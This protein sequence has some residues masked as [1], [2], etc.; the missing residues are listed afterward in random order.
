MDT[1]KTEKRPNQAGQGGGTNQA[2]DPKEKQ[3][4]H[5]EFE[6]GAEPLPNEG[7]GIPNEIFKE[8][9]DLDQKIKPH[10]NGEFD[11]HAPEDDDLSNR[12]KD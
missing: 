5:G 11:H 3:Q 8:Y 7:S 10:V 6:E 1:E 12:S 9:T 2:I 4:H